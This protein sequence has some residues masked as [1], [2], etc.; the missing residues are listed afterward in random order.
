MRNE[1]PFRGAA[2]PPDRAAS[3]QPS[4]RDSP[5]W[6]VQTVPARRR[7]ALH[8]P[9]DLRLVRLDPLR[10]GI[11]HQQTLRQIEQMV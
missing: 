1:F 9:L 10:D 6:N 11:V 3:P 4:W 2:S 7:R 8:A 5:G